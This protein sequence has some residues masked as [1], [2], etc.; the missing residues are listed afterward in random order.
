MLMTIREQGI[1]DLAN[2]IEGMAKESFTARKK[3][4]KDIGQM[5]KKQMSKN[6]QSGFGMQ[7]LGAISRL[8]G[9]KKPW[10][11]SKFVVY[12]PKRGQNP[13]AIV[14]TK[15]A[16]KKM[17]EGGLVSISWAFRRF[18]HKKGIHLR[19]KKGIISRVKTP[20]RP[21]FAI[22]WGQVKDRIPEQYEERFFYQLQRAVRAR[23]YRK[24]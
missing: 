21:L 10:G 14:T 24:R 7:P 16:N 8:L 23:K 11:K 22:T 17:E 4:V 9:H 15:G 18:L 19:G 12:T 2:E 5:V 13:Y 20:A 6:R 1:Q 3:A